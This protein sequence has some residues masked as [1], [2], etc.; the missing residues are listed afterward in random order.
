[1]TPQ[2]VF[3]KSSNLSYPLNVSSISS[4]LISL[5]YVHIEKVECYPLARKCVFLQRKFFTLISHQEL[6]DDQVR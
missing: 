6:L 4:E 3:S 5:L 1:M 2:L